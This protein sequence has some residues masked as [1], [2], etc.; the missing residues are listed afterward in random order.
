MNELQIFPIPSFT[1]NYIWCLHNGQ[2]AIVI[3]PGDAQAV[4]K[5]LD[6]RKLN[7]V[8]MLATHKH[9]DHTGGLIE[10]CTHYNC[11][12]YESAIDPQHPISFLVSDG[13]HI[14]LL[15]QD[16]EILGT[17]GHTRDHVSFL[18]GRFCFVGDTL[19]SAGCGRV[20]PDGDY[21][22]LFQ[23][24]NK[25]NQLP[26][27]TLFFPAHEYTLANLVFAHH[28]L[29][30]DRSIQDRLE[31]VKT[32]RK[33]GHSTL[34]TTLVS[35]RTHNIF[36][37]CHE[38]ALREAVSLHTKQSLSTPYEVFEALRRWKDAW[39]AK[40]PNANDCST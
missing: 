34:P 28:V 2:D 18:I 30:N 20:M 7:L 29:P 5:T 12:V 14:S 38:P 22:K 39:A 8:G 32:Q 11:P 16:I 10:L 3:C 9:S 13:N 35:E 27:N 26:S 1:S 25:L 19:F 21:K 36:L 37:R 31:A 15:G 23:S 17:P 6:E 4:I 33:R 40:T 24:L